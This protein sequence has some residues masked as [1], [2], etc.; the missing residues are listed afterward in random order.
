[1]CNFPHSLFLDRSIILPYDLNDCEVI[2]R[3]YYQE[4]IIMKRILVFLTGLLVC[5]LFSCSL[6]EEFEWIKV[7]SGDG[8][9]FLNNWD[10]LGT[11]GAITYE[12]CMFA[13]DKAG[14]LHIVGMIKNTSTVTGNSNLFTLP[15]NYRPATTQ[16]AIIE[17]FTPAWAGDQTVLYILTTGTVQAAGL[18]SHDKISFG[19]ILV[20]L[21]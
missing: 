11:E 20:K 21:D 13:K 15:E 6:E 12:D 5:F 9:P 2:N 18:S 16:S 10:H 14:L 17:V 4:R 7:G 1:M 19:H 8:P 3:I